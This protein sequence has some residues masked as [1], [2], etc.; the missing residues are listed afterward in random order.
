MKRL[1]GIISKI[2]LSHFTRINWRRRIIVFS[3]VCLMSVP[4]LYCFRENVFQKVE[5]YNYE[6]QGEETFSLDV[7]SVS[8]A[9]GAA[10]VEISTDID[11]E[12][13]DNIDMSTVDSSTFLVNGG[14][15]TGVFSYDPQVNIVK[16]NP[17]ADLAINTL[18]TVELTTGIKNLADD[19]MAA[20]FIWSFNTVN[21]LLPEIYILSPDGEILT[22]ETYDFGSHVILSTYPAVFTIWNNGTSNLN[23]TGSSLSGANSSEFN[24]S[25]SPGSPV[26]PGGSTTL[27]VDFIPST[28]GNKTVALTI[29]NDDADES[30]FIINFIA[31]SQPILAPA[32]EIKVTK[33]TINIVS[34]VTVVDFGSIKL[35][36]NNSITL[37]MSNIGSDDLDVLSYSITGSN[38]SDFSTAFVPIPVTILSG[39]TKSFTVKFSPGSKGNKYANLNFQN[40][41]ADENPFIIKLKGK[42]K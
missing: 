3:A 28:V 39:S 35:G 32:P 31:V 8:P 23:I 30:S 34:G 42:G 6:V 22:G 21:V 37:V 27:T 41:D 15:V 20:G 10:N 16:F 26:A 1:S 36:N 4:V 7:V 11:V 2:K 24:I 33:G 14:A 40:T 25:A 38:P 5:H 13:N 17:D 29:T 19:P 18:Y 9:D 12:F